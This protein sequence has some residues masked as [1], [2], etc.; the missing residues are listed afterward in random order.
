MKRNLYSV[1]VRIDVPQEGN[2]IVPAETPEHA[3]ELV[4][5]KFDNEK[6]VEIL[7]VFDMRDEAPE[8]MIK[9]LGGMDAV[10][11][12]ADETELEV[13]DDDEANKES[14]AESGANKPVL[15]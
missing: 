1:A 14:A 6:N 9:V 5:R 13:M 2:V 4:L 3:K 11:R 7:D 10:E 8:G 15:N 12:M